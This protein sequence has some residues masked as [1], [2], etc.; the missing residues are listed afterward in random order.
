MNK[1]GLYA[2]AQSNDII[3]GLLI[4]EKLL[5]M[6]LIAGAIW[7]SYCA[8]LVK[9][10]FLIGVFVMLESIICF[11]TGRWLGRRKSDAK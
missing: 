4:G 3:W 5:G 9:V 7:L 11:R 6:I 2:A 8:E 1:K 10:E